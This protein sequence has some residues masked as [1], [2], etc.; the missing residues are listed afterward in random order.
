MA[1]KK[2]ADDEKCIRKDFSMKPEQ[3][4]RLNAYCIKT[5]RALSWVIRKALDEYLDKYEN[6]V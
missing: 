4:E 2:I 1:R 3:Y 5:E 6:L